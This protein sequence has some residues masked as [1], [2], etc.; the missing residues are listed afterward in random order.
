MPFLP[1][2]KLRAPALQALLDVEV[3]EQDV[4]VSRSALLPQLSLGASA[5]KTWA[6][7][8][9]RTEA[10]KVRCWRLSVK[11]AVLPP[12]TAGYTALSAMGTGEGN[13][14]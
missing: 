1:V 4:R 9:R 14:R 6:G 3:A 13:G 5:G 11:P 8:Q 10:R 2:G 7:R 12:V